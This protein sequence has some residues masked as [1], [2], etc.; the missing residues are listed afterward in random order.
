MFFLNT[1]TYLGFAQ[2]L[3]FL[4]N[5]FYLS[6]FDVTNFLKVTR[7]EETKIKPKQLLNMDI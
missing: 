3:F 4:T 5:G 1:K 6:Y 7:M 2:S